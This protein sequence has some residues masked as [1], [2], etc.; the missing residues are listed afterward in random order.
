MAADESTA[1]MVARIYI[2]E[3][4]RDAGQARLDDVVRVL[5]GEHKVRGVTVFR[6]IA[7]FG[8][9]GEVQADD[10]LR[11]DAALPLVVEFVDAPGIVEAAWARLAPMLPRGHFVAWRQPGP[12]AHGA[13]L[14]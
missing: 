2:A 11:L 3:S 1:L 9:H 10:L 8:S 4:E 12:C 14:A 7:G 5:H 6:G 13:G